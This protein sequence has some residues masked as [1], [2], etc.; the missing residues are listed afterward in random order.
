MVIKGLH[1]AVEK[2]K[3]DVDPVNYWRDYISKPLESPKPITVED[4]EL[5]IKHDLD[6]NR[7]L[8]YYEK[9]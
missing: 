8:A 4:M 6:A 5:V 3:H 1:E 9:K 7:W 2:L